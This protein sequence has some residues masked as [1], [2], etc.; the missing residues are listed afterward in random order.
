MEAQCAGICFI[1]SKRFYRPVCQARTR[2][3]DAPMEGSRH[4]CS[5]K[6][7]L[8][9]LGKYFTEIDARGFLA[10]YQRRGD[11]G[12]EKNVNE[13]V[14]ILL[15]PRDVRIDKLTRIARIERKGIY[16]LTAS[17]IFFARVKVVR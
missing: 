11:F 1:T 7:K 6:N 16:P 17:K 13:Y 15:P 8:A 4:N 2:G 10:K 5:R 12:G 14:N 9:A 3:H